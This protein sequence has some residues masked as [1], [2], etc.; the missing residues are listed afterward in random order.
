MK[1]TNAMRLLTKGGVAFSVVEYEVDL[2]DLSATHASAVTGIDPSRMF[3]TL[4]LRGERNGYFVCCIPAD[5]EVDLKKAAVATADKKAE[6]IHVKELLPLTGY[7]RG[8]CSP[9]GMKKKFPTFIDASALEHE[10]IGVSGGARG[11][12]LMV[13]PAEL[14]EFVGAS[15]VP[16]TAEK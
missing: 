4:V 11:I 16:L 7:I 12:T 2:D 6:M 9:V 1:T 15:F 3:K 5:K 8:G 10:T 14:A 13:K